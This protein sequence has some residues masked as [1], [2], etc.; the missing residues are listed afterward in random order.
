MID[1]SDFYYFNGERSDD[2]DALRQQIIK[3]LISDDLEYVWRRRLAKMFDPNGDTP[4]KIELKLRK[5]GNAKQ[6]QQRE[7]TIDTLVEI[8]LSTRD[9]K[10]FVKRAA[11]ATGYDEKTIRDYRKEVERIVE[12]FKS[13]DNQL[14]DTLRK[15]RMRI[16]K[17]RARA[18]AK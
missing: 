7:K 17:F 2:E 16:A 10:N 11:E 12:E 5:R 1:P 3:I 13:E 6:R 15:L 18:N 9:P 4:F 8:Y 14:P